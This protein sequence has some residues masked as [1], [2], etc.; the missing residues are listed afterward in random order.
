METTM[1]QANLT[2]ITAAIWAAGDHPLLRRILDTGAGVTFPIHQDAGAFNVTFHSYILEVRGS[3]VAIRR[4]DGAERFTCGIDAECLDGLIDILGAIK[5][6]LEEIDA[7]YK[8]EAASNLA[9]L[10]QQA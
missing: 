4:Q 5:G 1:D 3:L 9:E 6:I 2:S 8:R 7:A 10:P